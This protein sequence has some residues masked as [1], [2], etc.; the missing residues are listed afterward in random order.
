MRS[1]ILTP[2]TVLLLCVVFSSYS[3]VALGQTDQKLKEN[4][5]VDVQL[6]GFTTNY[7]EQIYVRLSLQEERILR[8]WYFRGMYNR[9]TTDSG[10]SETKVVT[11]RLEFRHESVSEDGKYGV[12]TGM[13]SRRDRDRSKS[14]EHS[15]YHFVSYGIGKQLDTRSK[16]DLGLGFVRIYD[17]GGS[18]KPSVS[19]SIIG[20]DNLSKKLTADA[21]ILVLQPLDHLRSTKLDS[22]LGFSYE[23]TQGLAVRLSWSVNNLIRPVQ[24]D[25]DW[26]SIVRLTLSYRRVSV[27]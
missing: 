24:G 15:G 21:R 11:S 2:I 16:G 4:R 19:C 12:W 27:L 17:D 6:S 13:L 22:E 26:D 3:G 9:T 5:S 14:V 10:S 1:F 18:T 8:R 25:R 23:L 7:S 20:V